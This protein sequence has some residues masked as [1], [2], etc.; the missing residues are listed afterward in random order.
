VNAHLLPYLWLA[1]GLALGLVLGF[2]LGRRVAAH[3]A[4]K[5]RSAPGYCSP[6]DSQVYRHLGV[7]RAELEAVKVEVE[8]R[9]TRLRDARHEMERI[10]TKVA[11]TE[12]ALARINERL[13][14][15]RE[16]VR[17]RGDE[18]KRQL[19]ELAE[20]DSH[21]ERAEAEGR[22]RA[23]QFGQLQKEMTRTLEQIDQYTEELES[24]TDVRDKF[25]AEI[26]WLTQHV[27]LQD[28]ER[29]RLRQTISIRS[30]ELEE[31][32]RLLDQR[33]DEM[34]RLIRRR[35]D[36]DS[37]LSNLRGQVSGLADEAGDGSVIE[38]QP[39]PTYQ[40][41]QLPDSV[42]HVDDSDDLTQIRGIGLAYAHKLAAAGI[43]TYRQL[44]EADPAALIA[45]IGASEG[46]QP[47]V[48]AWIDQA[49]RL[50]GLS[51]PDV[52]STAPI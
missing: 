50:C 2:L 14:A 22:R 26:D 52:A 23:E 25:K 1:P 46:R 43:R 34:A 30:A 6:S 45:I 44:A 13:A 19:S 35:R 29:Y 5:A 33:D 21:I 16:R 37:G 27:Q 17:Q 24:L 49:Q 51:G 12:A 36:V 7:M 31:A 9:R 20:Q 3:S 32:Q 15:T 11:E 18:Y 38:L 47:N 41:P 48:Q 40:P 8:K 39:P 28:G 10:E 42:S 4:A